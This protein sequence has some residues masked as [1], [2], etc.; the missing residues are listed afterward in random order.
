MRKTRII[1]L[2]IVCI[3]T[4]FIFPFIWTIIGYFLSFLSKFSWFTNIQK[5]VSTYSYINKSQYIDFSS[6]LLCIVS[7]SV[8]GFAAYKLS[9]KS[10]H[11]SNVKMAL[12]VKIIFENSLKSI[13]NMYN[14]LPEIKIEIPEINFYEHEFTF[15][16]DAEIEL[17]YKLY[18]KILKLSYMQNTISEDDALIKEILEETLINKSNFKYKEKYQKILN[19]SNQF[20]KE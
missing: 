18:S 6:T 3:I 7:S 17:F 14:H 9:R 4:I 16:S 20:F 10:T 13:F 1:I 12:F 15:L 2:I 11:N 8:L 19:K 5:F